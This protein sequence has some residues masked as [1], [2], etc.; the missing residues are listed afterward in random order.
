MTRTNDLTHETADALARVLVPL[1]RS[2]VRA[3]LGNRDADRLEGHDRQPEP[4]RV[5]C[6]ACIAGE[7]EGAIKSGRRWVATRAA[8]AAWRAARA[9]PPP[10]TGDVVHLDLVRAAARRAGA[11]R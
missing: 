3:E 2:V 4:R 8:W 6:E 9:T 5:T 10:S 11:R 1:I 7:V